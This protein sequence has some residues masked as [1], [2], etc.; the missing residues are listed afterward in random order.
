MDESTTPAITR[1]TPCARRE[2]EEAGEAHE[3]ARGRDEAPVAEAVEE[4]A[5]DGSPRH[6]DQRR[7]ARRMPVS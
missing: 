7:A 5:G 4:M 1:P 6:G 2:D 3:G